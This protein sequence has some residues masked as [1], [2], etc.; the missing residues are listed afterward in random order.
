MQSWVAPDSSIGDL[1]SPVDSPRNHAATCE[2]H[3]PVHDTL[4]IHRHSVCCRFHAHPRNCPGTKGAIRRRVDETS[5]KSRDCRGTAVC[6]D[7]RHRA[8]WHVRQAQRGPNPSFIFKS[9]C[10]WGA[11]GRV[12]AAARSPGPRTTGAGR[13]GSCATQHASVQTRGMH[14]VLRCESERACVCWAGG[15]GILQRY[16]RGQRGQFVCVCSKA[17]ILVTLK[18][19]GSTFLHF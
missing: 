13:G 17:S 11:G 15:G 3:A 2:Y 1:E 4:H 19:R 6:R 10:R 12:W 8:V 5:T 16:T 14:G 9:L 7:S 18:L